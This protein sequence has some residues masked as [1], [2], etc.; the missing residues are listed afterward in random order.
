MQL[1]K[2]TDYAFRVLIYLAMKPSEELAT[3]QE[4]AEYFDISRSHMMKIVQ[5]L[6]NAGFVQS[7]RGKQGGIKLGKPSEDINL[8]SIIEL[9]E[10]TLK[11]VDC[12]TQPCR[13]NPGCGL[14]T[15]LFTGQRQYMEYIGQYTVSDL[16][17]QNNGTAIK[18][19][20]L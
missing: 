18:D 15:I 16:V 6:A 9:M 4:I 8:R 13:L 12:T 11:P 7:I 17:N 2:H 10:S 14:K 1:T 5:K 3:I 19:Q 20:L